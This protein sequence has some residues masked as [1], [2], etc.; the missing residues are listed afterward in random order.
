[1]NEKY[2]KEENNYKGII[3]TFDNKGN[4]I[5]FKEFY[6]KDDETCDN[7]HIIKE[8][9]FDIK[10][11]S[12]GLIDTIDIIDRA[13]PADIKYIK[14]YIYDEVNR[15]SDIMVF[16]MRIVNKHVLPVKLELEHVLFEYDLNDQLCYKEIYEYQDDYINHPL[17]IFEE[18]LPNNINA[19][20]NTVDYYYN[21]EYNREIYINKRSAKEDTYVFPKDKKGRIVSKLHYRNGKLIDSEEYYY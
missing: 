16:Y 6:R 15:I 21:T 1:M 11:N 4:M 19:G 20:K 17:E 13:N 5:N 12:I 14:Q 10:Y 2:N 3:K 18:R 9:V 7:I 8:L